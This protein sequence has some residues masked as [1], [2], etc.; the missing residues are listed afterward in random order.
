MSKLKGRPATILLSLTPP[1]W[2]APTRELGGVTWTYVSYEQLAERLRLAASE[3]TAAST[4]PTG[5][6]PAN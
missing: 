2:D 5:G 3:L 4:D 1:V 6:S